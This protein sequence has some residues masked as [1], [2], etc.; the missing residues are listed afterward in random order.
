MYIHLKQNKTKTACTGIPQSTP[1]VYTRAISGQTE[2]FYFFTSSY[3]GFGRCSTGRWTE[4]LLWV[5]EH[6]IND[7]NAK[8]EN[9]PSP[10]NVQ[11]G[12]KKGSTGIVL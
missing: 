5:Q 10:G 8:C 3:H 7:A 11:V 9:R 4:S 1:V 2:D 12:A 6:D